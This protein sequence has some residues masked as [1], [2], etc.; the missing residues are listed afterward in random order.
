M[1]ASGQAYVRRRRQ[2]VR[3]R[4]I[5]ET[6]FLADRML[7]MSPCPGRFIADLL[8]KFARPSQTGLL[9]SP[10]FVHLKRHC[11]ELLRHEEGHQLPRWTPLGLLPPTH[12]PLRIA[13]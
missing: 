4:D 9:T 5:D 11:L 1:A 7:V 8:L 13:L 3:D 2:E 6:L 12:S 10:D